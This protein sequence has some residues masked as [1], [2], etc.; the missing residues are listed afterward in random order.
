MWGAG[1]GEACSRS[2]TSSPSIFFPFSYFMTLN[3]LPGGRE[4]ASGCHVGTDCSW[5][6]FPVEAQQM[7]AIQYGT[8]V[9]NKPSRRIPSFYPMLLFVIYL[10]FLGGV[11]DGGRV[12]G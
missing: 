9:I 12:G 2:C 5:S 11:G 10:A 7:T 8:K 3:W 6:S 1:M 4:G